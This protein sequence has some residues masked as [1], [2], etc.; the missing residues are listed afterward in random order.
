MKSG[1][2]AGLTTSRIKGYVRIFKTENDYADFYAGDTTVTYGLDMDKTDSLINKAM[3]N[4]V[5]Y[6]E[7]N[8]NGGYINSGFGQTN[9]DS[10][11]LQGK[12][13]KKTL[14]LLK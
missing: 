8:G 13:L 7:S 1:D 5:H 9:Q 12:S 4:D 14:F 10:T 2:A 11:I 3:S 6:L